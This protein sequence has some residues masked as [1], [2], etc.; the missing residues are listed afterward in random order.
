MAQLEAYLEMDSTDEKMF[1]K[2]Q[3][4]REAEAKEIAK[5]QQR[6]IA[7]RKLDPAYKDSL[8]GGAVKSISSQDYQSNLGLGPAQIGGGSS[9]GT[10]G[11]SASIAPP[12]SSAGT[13]WMEETQAQTRK[14]PGKGMQLGKPKKQNELMKDLQKEKLF[15]KPQEAF[16]EEV[17]AEPVMTVN[18]LL[19]NV[20]IE[21]EEK[22]NCS[23]N[24]DGEISKFEIKGII[25]ITVNDPK[26]NNPA[27]QLSF[28]TVKG[29]TFKPHPELDK[30]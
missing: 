24:R 1:K 29:F 23:L 26:K 30:Q 10:G 15:S 13:S 18:P 14:A 2:M 3:L 22:V 11:S 6:E 8:V 12:K 17:K 7:K 27:A 16:T 20:V 9:G 19:E 5:K 25:Y 4:I 28:Q 21:V